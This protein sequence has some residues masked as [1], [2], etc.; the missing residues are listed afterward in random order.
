MTNL[1]QLNHD[2]FF[3]SDQRQLLWQ[4]RLDFWYE[5][6][7]RR[8]TLPARF[9]KAS[10][11][12]IYDYCH[13]S[14]RYF[15]FPLKLTYRNVEVRETWVAPTHL[16]R[17]WHLSGGMLSEEIHYDE[18]RC[19]SYFHEYLIKTPADFALYERLLLE[20]SW[21]WDQA[22]YDSAL[23]QVGQRGAPQFYFRRSPFQHLAISIMGYERSIFLLHDHP[24]V[25]SRY[26][27]ANTHAD[28]AM[29]EQL[30]RCP[31]NILNFG[32]NIDANLVS[33][34]IWRKH[35]LPYYAR[36]VDDLHQAGK[37]VNIHI[38]GAMRPLINLIRES[39]FDAIE[40]CTPLPQGD[41][42]LA[43]I[44]QAVGNRVLM[45]GIPAVYFLSYYSWETL[46]ACAQEVIN[47][48]QPR[49]ILG[50]SDELPPDADIERVRQVGEL[51]T[52]FNQEG[53]L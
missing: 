37:K 19:S 27:E 4:P 52:K 14:V 36:R 9:Q 35:L 50:V 41:V 22:A 49:L 31:A 2:I 45:D 20:E 32:E 3:A 34:T 33:P 11:M 24:E 40:A 43:E 10:L 8:G 46:A 53:R 39:P 38:D 12:D 1:A 17:E 51:V 42:T 16:R 5:V 25:Y 26:A 47:L 21:E 6:N 23:Q 29:Y 48:F 15:T 13:A 7:Q 18:W 30:C 44:K 28:N